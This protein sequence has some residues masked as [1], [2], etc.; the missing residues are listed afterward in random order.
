MVKAAICYEFGMPLVV[1]EVEIDP[2]KTGEVKVKIAACAICHS[3]IHCVRGAWGGKTPVVAGHEGAGTVSEVGHGVTR[4]RPGDPVVVSL[5]RSCGHCFY[6]TTGRPYNCE[7][8]F[9]LDSETRLHN[10]AGDSVI[11]GIYTGA[12]AE[13]AIV[14]QSQLVKIPESLP[15]DRACLLAC[16]VITGLGAVTNTVQ[17]ETGASVVVVGAGGVGLNSVQGAVLSGAAKIIAVDVRDV[18]LEAARRFG[19]THVIN[20][21][22][23]DAVQTVLSLTDGRGADYAFVTVGI[24]TAVTQASHMVHESGV[25]VVAG[26]P[27]NDDAAF[28]LNAHDMTCGRTIIGS[29]MG[30]SRIAVDVPRLVELYQQG[31]LK[32]DELI[33]HR[34]PLEK[35]NEAITSM[36]Q[37]EAIRNVIIF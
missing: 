35:I 19:A 22:N 24:S 15:M 23:R 37:G 29:K 20:V 21:S 34:Y 17:V 30:S 12:F 7:G 27:G 36:E 28:S 10:G 25:V 26:M 6:C 16:G 32:L 5:L 31:R 11:Q 4:V 3:D 9:A 1:E 2:P 8:K 33:T 13:Y 14:D 18:K